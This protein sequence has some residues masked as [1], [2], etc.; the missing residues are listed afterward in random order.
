MNRHEFTAAQ[1]RA[2]LEAAGHRCQDPLCGVSAEWNELCDRLERML[3]G[4]FGGCP[5]SLES[6]QR[7]RDLILSERFRHPRALNPIIKRFKLDGGALLEVDHDTE[8]ADGGDATPDNATVRCVFCHAFKT[9]DRRAARQR[10]PKK[11][12]R[13]GAQLTVVDGI[14]MNTVSGLQARIDQQKTAGR[15]AHRVTEGSPVLAASK[16]AQPRR[17][18]SDAEF[19]AAAQRRERAAEE[20]PWGA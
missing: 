20:W 11:Q 7:L 13:S 3:I 2:A 6:L 18:Y 14:R 5:L 12:E 16:S 15:L 19:T 9:E 1:K 8:C 17:H 10:A 4:L